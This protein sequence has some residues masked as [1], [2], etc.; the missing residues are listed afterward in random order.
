MFT[1]VFESV[2]PCVLFCVLCMKTTACLQLYC[3]CIC[4]CICLAVVVF[5]LYLYLVKSA[6][7][8]IGAE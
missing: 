1:F 7:V 8:A 2:V 3:S 5:V 4:K 6:C